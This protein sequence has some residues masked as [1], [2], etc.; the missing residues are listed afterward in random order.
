VVPT[1]PLAGS[2]RQFPPDLEIVVAAWDHLPDAIK[3][4]V[5]ALIQAVQAPQDRRLRR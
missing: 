1:L 3:T 4:G 2:V 5:L